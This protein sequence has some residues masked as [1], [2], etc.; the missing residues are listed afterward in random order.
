MEVATKMHKHSNP[1]HIFWTVHCPPT[2][3]PHAPIPA[4]RA[5]A[6]TRSTATTTTIIL[7]LSPSPPAVSASAVNILY[8]TTRHYGKPPSCRLVS[9]QQTRSPITPNMKHVTQKKIKMKTL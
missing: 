4:Y 9:Q 3:P 8:H 6:S 7:W 1:L 2:P 5:L